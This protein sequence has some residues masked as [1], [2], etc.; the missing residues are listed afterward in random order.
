MYVENHAKKLVAVCANAVAVYLRD[1]KSYSEVWAGLV[2]DVENAL[3]SGSG[4]DSGCKFDVSASRPDKLVFT[5]SFHHMND[6]GMYDGWTDHKVTVVPSLMFGFELRVSG[7]DRDGIKDY[8][9]EAFQSVLDTW[10]VTE[11]DMEKLTFRDA[12]YDYRE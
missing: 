8:I 2:E 11:M 9:A 12:K 10:V 7:K 1:S 3:P 6:A 5:T 4:F